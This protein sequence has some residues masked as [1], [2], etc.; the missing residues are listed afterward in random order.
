[1][2]SLGIGFEHGKLFCI[3]CVCMYRVTEKI[4]VGM[5]NT[6]ICSVATS[7]GSWGKDCIQKE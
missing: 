7:L 3:V 4:G 1:M 5:K 2:T 6:E